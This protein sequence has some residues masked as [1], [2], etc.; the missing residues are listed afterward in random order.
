MSSHVLT[1]D[2]V[3][4][5][6]VSLEN[7]NVCRQIRKLA[8]SDGLTVDTSMHRSGLNLHLLS[9]SEYCELGIKQYIKSYLINLQPFMLHS[10]HTG[11]QCFQ[12]FHC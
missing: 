10:L 12:I 1:I 9:Y 5:N 3:T 7:V 8:Q 4:A 6:G 2:E 11:I